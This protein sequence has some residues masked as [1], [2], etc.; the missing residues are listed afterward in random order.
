MLNN[1]NFK[2]NKFTTVIFITLEMW[3]REYNIFNLPRDYEV[4]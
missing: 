4:K 3:K 1:S 2:S